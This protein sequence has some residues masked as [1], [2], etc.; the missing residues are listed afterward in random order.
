MRLIRISSPALPLETS[1]CGS[2]HSIAMLTHQTRIA[3]RT[4]GLLVFAMAAPLTVPLAAAP[5][6]SG[7]QTLQ[8]E[9]PGY[10]TRPVQVLI[11]DGVVNNLGLVPLVHEAGQL[12]DL[13]HRVHA[14]LSERVPANA[15]EPPAAATPPRAARAPAVRRH[16]RVE[17]LVAG[18]GR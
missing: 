13:L 3:I 8:L 1:G 17:P 7:Q 9:L 12:I 18:A 4:L 10:Q 11:K 5:L 2:I 6:P 15:A 14:T 16:E